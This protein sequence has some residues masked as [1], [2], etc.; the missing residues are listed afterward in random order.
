M[1]VRGWA[2]LYHQV[3]CM[4]AVLFMVGRG[5]EE[6]GIVPRLLDV[7]PGARFERKPTYNM[8]PELPLVLMD[9]TCVAKQRTSCALLTARCRYEPA[10]QWT[11][12]P[13]AA[14]SLEDRVFQQLA[15]ALFQSVVVQCVVRQLPAVTVDGAAFIGSGQRVA[16]TGPGV[17]GERAEAFFPGHGNAA[18]SVPRFGLG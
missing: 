16:A 7:T 14:R 10:L 3:R 12:S 18:R 4:M 5:L 15:E 11:L 1:R 6:P 2:F 17:W 8:A 13:C 9:V